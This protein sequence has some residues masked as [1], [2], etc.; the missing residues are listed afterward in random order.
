MGCARQRD[1]RV[2][3]VVHGEERG[4]V[5]GGGGSSSSSV[6]IHVSF[7]EGGRLLCC[8]P[9]LLELDAVEEGGWPWKKAS[10]L[11]H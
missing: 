7:V 4:G 2:D 5:E 1:G 11:V 9:L 3:R 10:L 8:L 6:E